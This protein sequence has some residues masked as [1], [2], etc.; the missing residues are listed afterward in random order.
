MHARLGAEPSGTW[1]EKLDGR[2]IGWSWMKTRIVAT[3][4]SQNLT[5]TTGALPSLISFGIWF[6]AFSHTSSIERLGENP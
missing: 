4:L 3:A 5:G 6:D 1:S 2:S